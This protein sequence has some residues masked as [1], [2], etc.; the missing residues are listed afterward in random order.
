MPAIETDGLT[1]RFGDLT[2]VDALNLTVEDGEVFGFLGRTA[3]GS[4]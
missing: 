2:A 1:R 3:P 4:P